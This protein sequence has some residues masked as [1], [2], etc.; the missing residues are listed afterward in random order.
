[1]VRKDYTFSND[2]ETIKKLCEENET[3]A[4]ALDLCFERAKYAREHFADS[5]DRLSGWAHNFTCSACASQMI[6]DS[7]TEYRSGNVFTCPVCGERASSRDHD[8][9]WV[10]YYRSKYADL[11]Y[12]SAVK[13][14]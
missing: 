10:Y 8:E 12:S 11:A 2:R 5:A 13:P 9:A 4:A 14:R 1:M 6:F 7:D 3:Y